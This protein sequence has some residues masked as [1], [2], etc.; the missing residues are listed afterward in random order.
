MT[1]KKSHKLILFLLAVYFCLAHVTT[2]LE[3]SNLEARSVQMEELL[4]QQARQQQQILA[5]QKK[6]MSRN[7]QPWHPDT[8]GIPDLV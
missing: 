8:D 2:R 4:L 1:F 3:L 6:S 5:N 7:A